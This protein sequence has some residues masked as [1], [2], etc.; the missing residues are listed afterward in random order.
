MFLSHFNNNNNN[1]NN[2]NNNFILQGSKLREFGGHT[3]ASRG[4]IL[5]TKPKKFVAY[6]TVKYWSQFQAVLYWP[7]YSMT[8]CV[9]KNAVCKTCLFVFCDEF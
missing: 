1:N 2:K 7:L 3:L 5:V 4:K 9:E 8:R 6:A